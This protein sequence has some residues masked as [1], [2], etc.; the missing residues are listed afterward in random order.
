MYMYI[1]N[2]TTIT[3][4]Y[5]RVIKTT[6]IVNIQYRGKSLFQA[7]GALGIMQPNAKVY[8]VHGLIHSSSTVIN[9]P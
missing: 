5:A 3:L 9:S 1:H 8:T 6:I 7:L 2:L 4:A